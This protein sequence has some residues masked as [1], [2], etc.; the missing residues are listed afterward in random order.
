MK[1]NLELYPFAKKR[2]TKTLVEPIIRRR[3]AEEFEKER[4]DQEN[5]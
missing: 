2:N 4:L 1:A 3:I 5:E